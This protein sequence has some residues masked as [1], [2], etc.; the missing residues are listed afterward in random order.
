MSI[1][2]HD[3]GVNRFL[4]QIVYSAKGLEFNL[5]SL[6]KGKWSVAICKKNRG[7]SGQHRAPYRL[8]RREAERNDC[9]QRVSQKITA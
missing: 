8:K 1:F 6:Q 5:L 3:F 9:L 4:K 7:K 2:A